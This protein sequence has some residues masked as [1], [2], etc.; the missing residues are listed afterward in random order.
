MAYIKV[1]KE[2]SADIDLYYEDHG[3]GRPVVLIHGYPLSGHSW[4]KQEAALLEAGYRVITYDRRGFGRSSQPATGY[5][6]D[7]FAADLGTVLE[8]LELD[9][10][11]LV[12]FSMGAGEVFRYLKAHGS[13]RVRS[14]VLLGPLGPFLR[15]A[16]DNPEGVP[17]EY[18]EGIKAAIRADRPAAIKSFLDNFYNMDVLGGTLVSEPAWQDSFNVALGS[19][20]IAAVKCVDAWL[21]DFRPD[22]ASI[23]IPVLVVQGDADRILPPPVTGDR[24]PA[25]LRD[26]R[27]VRIEGGPHAI[28]W[29]HAEQVNKELLAFLS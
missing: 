29:T 4:E 14:T 3:T 24:L 21:E 17:T 25:V 8:G 19:S 12:G 22:L 10:V 9:D 20:A 11:T 26:V 27:H 2:N 1:G 5:D 16:D 18:F 23:E 28:G 6:F 15:K 13:A 7:T